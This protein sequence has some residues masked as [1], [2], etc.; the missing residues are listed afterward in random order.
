MIKVSDPRRF[1]RRTLLASLGLSGAFLPL[2]N[3]QLAG[4][5][6]SAFPKRLVIMVT[7][8]GTIQNRFWPTGGASDFVLNEI[9]TPL[10]PHR[11]DILIVKGIDMKSAKDDEGVHG[12]HDN[13]CHTLTGVKGYL[14]PRGD[15]DLGQAIVAA[16]G[17]SIDQQIVNQLKPQTKLASLVMGVQINWTALQQCRLSW[18]AENQ[19]VTPEEDPYRLFNTLFENFNMPEAMVD[20]SRAEGRSILDYVGKDLERF[21]GRLGTEDRARVQAHLDALRELERG[22]DP[23]FDATLT[24]CSPPVQGEKIDVKAN[25]NYPQVGKLQMDLL[26]SA[27]ACD[28]TRVAT[29]EWNSGVGNLVM[30]WL[31]PEF[32]GD[33]DE[34]PTRNLHDMTHR[35][36]QSPD[37]TNRKARTDQWHM[38][39][40]A[41]FLSRLKEVKE[42]DGTMLDNTAVCLINHMHDGA[43][44]SHGPALPVVLAGSCGGYFK[45]GRY[46]DLSDSPVPHNNLLVELANAVGAE[47]T[48]FGDPQYNG[49]SA[50]SVLR[51]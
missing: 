2:L 1:S 9:T 3:A 38:E 18:T 11:S 36:G 42:G 5:Q 29:F 46:I 4:A 50:L 21:A 17:I 30:S 27:L 23:K 41:Y 35:A 8:E 51:A 40:F 7:P 10:E 47:T 32:Q 34:F 44:H 25:P 24:G 12:A 49:S 33:G 26:V 6:A 14:G 15:H 19:S 45:P 39:Q 28:M 16:G 31:G 43:A 48:S 13:V 37:H 22:L 20:K